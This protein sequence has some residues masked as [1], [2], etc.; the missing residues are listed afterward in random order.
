MKYSKFIKENLSNLQLY[1][2][3][4]IF[5]ILLS[6]I[7]CFFGVKG[8]FAS[9]GGVTGVIGSSYKVVYSSN[10]PV[11]S[12]GENQ[13]IETSVGSIYA[14]LDN[15]FSVP[16]GYEFSG[17]NT[18]SD[19][20]GTQY[21]QNEFIRVESNLY[22][23]A[24]WTLVSVPDGGIEDINPGEDDTTIGGEDSDQTGDINDNPFDSEDSGDKVTDFD[25][26]L[27]NGDDTMN[28][29][30]VSNSG[31][32]V[33]GSAS[34]G[35]ITGENSSE[36]GSSSGNVSSD[37]INS[38]NSDSSSIKDEDDSSVI[39][40]FKFVNGNIEFANTSCNALKD[41]T[42]E[43]LLPKDKPIKEGYT[44]K[45]WS[46]SNLCSKDEIIS[47][48]IKVNKSNIYYACFDVNIDLIDNGNEWIYLI[49]S[50][51]VIAGVAIY[52]SIRKFRKSEIKD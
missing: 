39:Y 14:V 22:L 42:C 27:N 21:V 30:D 38:N 34:S 51:W 41:K 13:E 47:N 6:V 18:L 46:L 36:S 35:G 24:Q 26:N 9:F 2:F 45:G 1:I 10:W 52:F 16:D 17:W 33:S 12:L 23:Y 5:A 40:Q 37:G 8:T 49:I 50:V 4:F 31:G 3:S 44:F 28:D 32:T 43:L 20:T 25:E 48:S 15:Q 29:S 19:G 7:L 11:G